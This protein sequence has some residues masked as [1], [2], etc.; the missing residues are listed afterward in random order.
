MW[1]PRDRD[2][3]EEQGRAGR[4]P[5]TLLQWGRRVIATESACRQVRR[6]DEQ[7]ASMGPPRDRDGEYRT[8]CTFA[9][10]FRFR[11]QWGRRVIATESGIDLDAAI[12]RKNA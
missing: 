8:A 3:E 5:G 2:G 12:E 6:Y 4:A 1:P 7:C 11:L 9:S 10:L